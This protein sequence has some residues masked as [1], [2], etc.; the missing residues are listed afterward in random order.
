MEPKKRKTI[1]LSK[2]DYNT[3]GYYFITIC[4]QGKKCLLSQIV[5]DGV[6]DVPKTILSN[7]GKIAQQQ[8][9]EINKTYTHI[10]IE[11]YVIMPNHIHFIVSV[12]GGCDGVMLSNVMSETPLKGT[13]R[14]PSPTNSEIPRLISTFKRFCNKKYNSN[15]WQR[16][17]YDHI[18]RDR[19]D[20]INHLEYINNN[21]SK[22]NKD[23][24]YII[25]E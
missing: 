23:K 17:Y 12:N 7:Y 6:L 10:N 2:H 5:G 9:L 25:E 1:R 22:W 24:Y 18:I 3:Q 16:A 11:N 19:E 8:I 15:I 14:T 4:V 20:Y 21:P 13:S